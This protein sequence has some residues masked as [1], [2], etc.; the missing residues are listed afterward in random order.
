MVL[1]ATRAGGALAGVASGVWFAWEV[2]LR[3]GLVDLGDWDLAGAFLI[4]LL[5]WTQR[6]PRSERVKWIVVAVL[7][8]GGVFSS[9]LMIVPAGVLLGHLL[10]HLSRVHQEGWP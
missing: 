5:L 9:W 2:R 7:M 3:H 4:A 1:A 6:P 8:I 10:R